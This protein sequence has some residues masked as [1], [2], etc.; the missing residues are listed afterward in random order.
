MYWTQ[1]ADAEGMCDGPKDMVAPKMLYGSY[2]DQKDDPLSIYQYYREAIR[3]RNIY[4]VIARGKVTPLDQ[5]SNDQICAFEK[6]AENMKS[7][8]IVINTSGSPQ[9]VDLSGQKDYDTLSSV[10]TTTAE[11]IT[12]DGNKLTLPA[13]DIAVLTQ[14]AV[15]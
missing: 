13:Y 7:V 2:E 9:T 5:V 3:L 10:L 12:L 1:N 4:P 6:T 8:M 14:G 11:N 15:E